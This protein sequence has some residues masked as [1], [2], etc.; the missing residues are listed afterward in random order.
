MFGASRDHNQHI[1]LASLQPHLN[2]ASYHHWPLLPH[3]LHLMV[4]TKQTSRKSTGGT[5]LQVIVPPHRPM[6]TTALSA[7]AEPLPAVNNNQVRN[8]LISPQFEPLISILE[9]LLCLCWWR[10][11]VHVW[12]VSPGCLHFTYTPSQW[13]QHPGCLLRLYGLSH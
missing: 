9:T 6:A 11:P 4:R 7:S 10:G 8:R 5:A 1:G 2:V 13:Q 3:L 12:Q